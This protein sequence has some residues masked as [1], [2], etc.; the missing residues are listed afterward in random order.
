MAW[1]GS[2]FW[3]LA[4]G[5]RMPYTSV[6]H[7]LNW[8][9]VTRPAG[10]ADWWT[11]TRLNAL[12]HEQIL[13]LGSTKDGYLRDGQGDWS[14]IYGSGS[15]KDF[16]AFDHR[17]AFDHVRGDVYI[18]AGPG[19]FR[20]DGSIRSIGAPQTR[21]DSDADGIPDALDEFPGDGAEYVD[22][23][24]DGLGNHADMDDDGDG[25]PDAEDQVP[26]D[27]DETVD[28]DGDGIGDSDDVDDDGD[29]APD[30]VDAFPFDETETRDSDGDGIGDWRDEDDDGDGVPDA[31]DAF[32]LYPGE[33]FDTDGDGIGNNADLDDDADGRPD[34]YDP[35]PMVGIPGNPVLRFSNFTLS[36]ARGYAVPLSGTGDGGVSYPP[37]HGRS[38]PLRGI[39]PG[40]WSSPARAASWS[41]I[42]AGTLQGSISTGT[43]T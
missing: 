5:P 41:T 17:V 12:D 7:G 32:R 28:T 43:E 27:P 15:V 20:L 9:A 39:S 11:G 8:V 40:R 24:G 10:A 30:V 38:Q 36:G 42:C 31:Q 14:R 6:D 22:T 4:G 16:S 1:D 37:A 34:A 33:W 35:A 29:G 25:V 3:A 23:D 19:V 2:R 13:I 26:L 21:T 18:T